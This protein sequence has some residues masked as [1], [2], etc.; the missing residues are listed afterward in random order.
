VVSLERSS[1][2]LR[3][4]KLSAKEASKLVNALKRQLNRYPQS[5]RRTIPY[6]NGFRECRA[7]KN[8]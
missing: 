6:D 1:R 2:F 8:Q 3:I 4:S 5:L 7:P